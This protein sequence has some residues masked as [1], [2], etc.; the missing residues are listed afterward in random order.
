ME[1]GLNKLLESGLLGVLLFIALGGGVYLF[2][3]LLKEKDARRQDIMENN[4]DFLV[5]LNE[6]RETVKLLATATMKRK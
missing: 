3:A 6:I 4:K 1:A 5:V 2:Q